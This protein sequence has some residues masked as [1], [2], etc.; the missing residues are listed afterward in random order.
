MQNIS[1]KISMK[2]KPF[3]VLIYG[4]FNFN[5]LAFFCLF[6]FFLVFKLHSY[7]L[8][9][10]QSILAHL[11]FWSRVDDGSYLIVTLFESW[12]LT[13]VHVRPVY[14]IIFW[15]WAMFHLRV[16][17]ID[18]DIKC[19]SNHLHFLWSKNDTI[20]VCKVYLSSI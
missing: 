2:I 1:D 19:K 14:H 20:L 4:I 13:L 3:S 6:G 18:I 8:Q 10:L 12:I 16:F 17:R 15:A 7:S 9:I 11:I 5:C